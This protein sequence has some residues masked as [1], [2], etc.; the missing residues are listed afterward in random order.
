MAS[1]FSD[2]TAAAQAQTTVKAAVDALLTGLADMVAGTGDAASLGA[3]LA[4]EACNL[5]RACLHRVDGTAKPAGGCER[6]PWRA[7]VGT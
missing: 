2:I 1:D 3:D 4:A 5:S 7:A 6:E